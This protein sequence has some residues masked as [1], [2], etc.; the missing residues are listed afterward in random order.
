M[1]LGALVELGD[2]VAGGGEH[3]RVEAVVAVVRP[4]GEHVLGEGGEVADVDPAVVEV[5]PERLGAPVAQGE[6]GGSFG[7]VGEPHQLG[8]VQRA[9]GGGDVAQDAAGADRG[10]LLVVADE[11][12]LPAACGDELRRRRRG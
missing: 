12:D 3:E 10:E 6:G 8:Q 5:E 7:G 2:E 9:V 1:G 11:A 4:G